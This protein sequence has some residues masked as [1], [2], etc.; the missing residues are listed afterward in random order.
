MKIQKNDVKVQKDKIYKRTNARI[1]YKNKL[2]FCQF[3]TLFRFYYKYKIY[4]YVKTL[5][6]LV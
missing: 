6:L 3:V 4:F 5:S 2:L 1:K